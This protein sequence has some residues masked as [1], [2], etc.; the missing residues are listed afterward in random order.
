M[1]NGVAMMLF[2]ILKIQLRGCPGM[3]TTWSARVIPCLFQ[4]P[5]RVSSLNKHIGCSKQNY[6]KD[7]PPL[8]SPSCNRNCLHVVIS[9]HPMSL[10]RGTAQKE[11]E[12]YYGRWMMHAN[13]NVLL[14]R[15]ESLIKNG[16]TQKFANP[17]V[18]NRT[19]KLEQSSHWVAFDQDVWDFWN[20]T[21]AHSRSKEGKRRR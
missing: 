3:G 9:R 1:L 17:K 19:L 14:L 10:K 5:V 8:L 21:H 13:K 16:C 20:Y 18:A 4:Q 2:G 12:H 11:W 15:F 7:P 6:L